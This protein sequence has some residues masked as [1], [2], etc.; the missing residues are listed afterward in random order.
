MW[1]HLLQKAYSYNRNKKKNE[2]TLHPCGVRGYMFCE[3]WMFWVSNTE[4]NIYR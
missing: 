4:K 1:F 3:V 2:T